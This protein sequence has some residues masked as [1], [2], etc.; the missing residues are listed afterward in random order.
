MGRNAG[1]RKPLPTEQ[2]SVLRPALL[3]VAVIVLGA[4]GVVVAQQH[5]G[6]LDKNVSSDVGPSRGLAQRSD[7]SLS[8][9]S[10]S[11]SSTA[12]A[13][14]SPVLSSPPSE[15][16]PGPGSPGWPTSSVAPSYEPVTPAP[17]NPVPA[18]SSTRT[19]VSAPALSAAPGPASLNNPPPLPSSPAAAPGTADVFSGA[20]LYVDPDTTAAQ[21]RAA[22][23]SAAAQGARAV[24]GGD[25]T[26]NAAAIARIAGTAQ[27]HWFTAAT[28][29]SAVAGQVASYL[30][31]AAADQSLPVL[32]LDALPRLDCATLSPSGLASGAEYNRWLAQVV[33]GFDSAQSADPDAA[34]AAVILEPGALTDT[35]CLTSVQLSQQFSALRGAVDLLSPLAGLGLYLDAGTSH[36]LTPQVVASRLR[37][38]GV[39]KARGFSLNVGNFYPTSEEQRYGET[40]S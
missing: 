20:T 34:Q 16:T 15:L 3:V 2:V 22:D 33:A 26:S 31:S 4:A 27:A 12:P 13:T 17:A 37:S 11:P 24:D 38:V 40:L 6:G 1:E 10:T 23:L 14:P 9:S 29:T 5:Y 25:P 7:S 8:Q 19:G 32:V 35:G 28:P 36:A 39:A 21:A 30:R 18:G